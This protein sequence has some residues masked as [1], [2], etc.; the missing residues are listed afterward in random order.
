[1]PIKTITKIKRYF[2]DESGSSVKTLVRQGYPEVGPYDTVEELFKAVHN[3]AAPHP[4]SMAAY[5]RRPDGYYGVYQGI[6][7][8]TLPYD[9]DD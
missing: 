3:I 9:Q 8:T 2:E 5:E 6:S 7:T 4:V 1:M